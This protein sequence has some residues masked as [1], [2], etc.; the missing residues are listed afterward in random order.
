MRALRAGEEK[1]GPGTREGGREGGREGFHTESM[2]PCH[3]V[4]SL[5][6]NMSLGVYIFMMHNK[7]FRFH[8]VWHMVPQ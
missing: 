5:G 7:H 4:T 3:G 6:V 1:E 2:L 8:L